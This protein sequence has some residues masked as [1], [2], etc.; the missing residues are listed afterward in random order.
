VHNSLFPFFTSTCSLKTKS[1]NII[2]HIQR[3]TIHQTI[4]T[5]SPSYQTVPPATNAPKANAPKEE[6]SSTPVPMMKKV[7]IVAMVGTALVVGY[8]YGASTNHAMIATTT[9]TTTSAA[10]LVRGGVRNGDAGQEDF[11]S[12][13]IGDNYVKS[14]TNSFAEKEEE[15]DCIDNSNEK[16]CREQ[17]G[18]YWYGGMLNTCWFQ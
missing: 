2:Y 10:N 5:M 14:V 9:M 16:A 11:S 17:K 6:R 4:I 3:Q 1:F 15:G 7:G 13:S 8:S 12:T 18:C